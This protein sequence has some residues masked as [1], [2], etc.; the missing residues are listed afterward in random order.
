MPACLAAA[1][2]R[3]SLSARPAPASGFASTSVRRVQSARGEL[4]IAA[5]QNSLRRQRLEKR[6]TAYNKEYTE[7]VKS[8]S[9]KVLKG[10][11]AMLAEISSVSSEGDLATVDKDMHVAFS[12]IDKAAAKGILHKNTAARRK[13]KLTTVRKQVLAAAGIYGAQAPRTGPVQQAA[14]SYQRHPD[15]IRGQAPRLSI[16]PG[17]CSSKY[18]CA[19][20]GVPQWIAGSSC[21]RLLWIS[22]GSGTR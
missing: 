18:C 19:K 1:V 13:A 16:R 3:L 17:S 20:G 7:L 10:Y 5:A 6:K 21:V 11:Q 4:V 15:W 8:S 22:D 2:Q 9:R 14:R 12:N